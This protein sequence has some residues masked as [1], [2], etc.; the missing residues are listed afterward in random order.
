MNIIFSQLD[1]AGIKTNYV[2]LFYYIISIVNQ[3]NNK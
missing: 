1:N 2:K 3:T